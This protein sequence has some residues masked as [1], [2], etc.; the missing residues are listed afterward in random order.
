MGT[1]F[2]LNKSTPTKEYTAISLSRKGGVY[3]AT[4]PLF[5]GDDEIPVNMAISAGRHG[6]MAGLE[7]TFRF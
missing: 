3:K 5:S 1:L 2:I 4:A 7:V 6:A